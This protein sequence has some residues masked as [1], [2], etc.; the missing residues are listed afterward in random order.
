MQR[1]LEHYWRELQKKMNTEQVFYLFMLLTF[2]EYH[3]CSTRQD[4]VMNEGEW[5]VSKEYFVKIFSDIHD[6]TFKEAFHRFSGIIDWQFIS[7]SREIQ[8]LLTIIKYE[9][10]KYFQSSNLQE[11]ESDLLE[12]MDSILEVLVELEERNGHYTATPKSIQKLLLELLGDY[13]RN[14]ITELCCGIGGLGV[15]FWKRLARRNPKIE[16]YGVDLDST[17]CNIA[18][19]NL[20]FHGIRNAEVEQK[21]LLMKPDSL[22]EKLSD[23]IIMDIPR[24]NNG[25]EA[26][27]DRDFRLM[28]HNRK[29]IYS[30]WIFIQDM[31]YRLEQRGM[32]AVLVTTGALI[33]LNEKCLREQLVI[34]DWL[35]AVITLPMN[36]YSNTRIG[37]E[38]LIFNKAKIS[39]RQKK[40]LFVDISNFSY[41]AQR[42]AD[43]ISEEGIEIVR[44]C[45]RDWKEIEGISTIQNIDM[46]D[47]EVYSLK[48][49][50]Y[51]QY[52]SNKAIE[53]Q[54]TLQDIAQIV[55]GYQVMKKE[56]YTVSEEEETGYFL[57]IKDIQE[58]RICFDTAEKISENHPAWKDKFRIEADDLLITSKG[59]A[60]K[61]ALVES[62]PPQAFISGNLTLI[63]V[64]KGKYHPYILYEYLNSERGRR[65]LEQIQSGT[66]IRILNNTSLLRLKVP[67]FGLEKMQDIGENLKRQ[68]EH[69]Y[70]EQK[71]LVETYQ[72]KRK[73]LLEILEED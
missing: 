48:P 5:K 19:L 70:R 52:S 31:L 25:Q 9:L 3:Q 56:L 72:S 64:D 7:E 41:R 35:E 63:R 13:R 50:Q 30:D 29:M 15:A 6:Y 57:N 62:K 32:A 12:K 24:G 73:T 45:F 28:Q 33:R 10:K 38:L 67:E 2:S 53:S 42:N 8:H 4:E 22:F 23:L 39:E 36:L 43:A 47:T 71:C 55:R 54:T 14:N 60:I 61:M 37:T 27:D 16:F 34:N 46:V 21:D 66:T 18:K 20:Y 68:R 69:F 49:M 17:I 58:E 59:T 44:K 1:I 51:I 65:A 40:I 11:N 26:Y